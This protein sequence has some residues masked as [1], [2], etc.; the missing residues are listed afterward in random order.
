MVE[1][2]LKETRTLTKGDIC[3]TAKWMQPKII[4]QKLLGGMDF[5]R[6]LFKDR[7]SCWSEIEAQ[8]DLSYYYL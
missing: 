7:L 8:R 4:H 6:G 3:G 2:K 1:K 5:S